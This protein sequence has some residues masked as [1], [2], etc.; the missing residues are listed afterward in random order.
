MRLQT[1]PHS[2]NLVTTP[3]AG[4]S[5]TVNT[6]AGASTNIVVDGPGNDTL[7]FVG[8]TNYWHVGAGNDTATLSG[9]T[10]EAYFT[11]A[12]SQY[13]IT[14]NGTSTVTVKNTATSAT[15][16]FAPTG[17]T[18]ELVFA[19]GASIGLG[20]QSADDSVEYGGAGNA[21]SIHGCAVANDNWLL[22]KVAV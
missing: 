20:N 14:Y 6:I 10:T 12:E 21:D 11:G 8:G 17:G 15:D 16:T 4:G 2:S 19:S 13:T 9:G 22:H 7:S 18:G 3:A 1:P 5:V